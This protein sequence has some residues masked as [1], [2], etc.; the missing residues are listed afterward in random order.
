SSPRYDTLQRLEK[1]LG[2]NVRRSY[3]D[4]S[5]DK[6]LIFREA[7][8]EDSAVPVVEPEGPEAWILPEEPQLYGTG[9]GSPIPEFHEKPQGDYTT[10]DLAAI[11]ED[12]H[13]EL[14]DGV[15]IKLEAPTRIHQA[16]SM[17]LCVKLYEFIEENGGK[18]EVY[19]APLDVRLDRD[20]KTMVEPD[21]LVCCEPGI[22]QDRIEGAPD[23]C[24]EILSP[25]TRVKDQLLK[26]YKYER[27]G[28]REFW[29]VDPEYRRV[30]VYRFGETTEEM[31][32]SMKETVPVG[33]YDGRCR[34]DFLPLYRKLWGEN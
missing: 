7:R 8:P 29:A 34:I 10:E 12:Q 4:V 26:R 21:I 14:I 9:G 30:L 2:Y 5:A 6:P 3:M 23:F 28:V 33:I 27:A 15:L 16:I 25:S 17:Y 1:A 31:I 32:Y 22:M 20:N 24:V 18:C 13:Y 11:P 19:A